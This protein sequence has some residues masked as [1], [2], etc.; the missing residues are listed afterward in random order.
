MPMQNLRTKQY[1]FTITNYWKQTY[2]SVIFSVFVKKIADH[3][4]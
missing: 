4:T 1:I 2:L 3:M